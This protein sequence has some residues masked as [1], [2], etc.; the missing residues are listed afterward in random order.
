MWEIEYLIF[1]FKVHRPA[2]AGPHL[3][4]S[5]VQSGG[6]RSHLQYQ[7]LISFSKRN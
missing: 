4:L 1:N 2:A 3:H 5:S 7:V 6:V